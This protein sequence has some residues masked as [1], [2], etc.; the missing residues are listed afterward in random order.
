MRTIKLLSLVVATSIFIA[1]C[2]STTSIQSEPKGAKLYMDNQPV[3]TTPYIY[4]DT[5]IAGTCTSIRLE[6]DGYVPFHTTLCR[7][8]EADIGA[9]VGGVFFLFPFL[10]TMKYHPMH[11]YELTPLDDT[12][13]EVSPAIIS[14]PH[15][16]GEQPRTAPLK[17]KTDRLREMKELLDEGI[18]TQEEY[19]IEK[20]KIL[21][22]E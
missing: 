6:K 3:G 9:I 19:D 1:S 13:I 4:S 5:K 20:Q 16:K 11:I 10:W 21:N 14:A 22:E 8:E 18:L 12:T 2:S 7:D 17:S 15:I